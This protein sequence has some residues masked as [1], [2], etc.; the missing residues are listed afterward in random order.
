M[1][2]KYRPGYVA[3]ERA[4]SKLGLASRTQANQ[5]IKAG[6]VQVNGKVVRD[7]FF[8]VRPEVAQIKI[9][10]QNQEQ[11]FALVI[12]LN[13][14]KGL[15]TTR[16]DEKNRP[17]IYECLK[18]LKRHVIPVG[19]LDLATSG[20]LLLTND[21]RFSDWVTDPVNKVKKVY[22]ATVRGEVSQD[23]LEK[24][25]RG[26][27]DEGELLKADRAVLEKS[28]KRESHLE[29]TLTE[30]KNREIRRL[31]KALGHEVSRLKRIQIGGLSLGELELGHWRSLTQAEVNE[32]FPGT[33]FKMT[34]QQSTSYGT[35]AL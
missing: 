3:L 21:T 15:V 16:S 8:A 34:W 31:C 1:P 28:S 20:L 24:M 11:E 18:D 7:P 13:K 6:R 2:S 14:P 35:S 26:I 30:G 22:L 19:R 23:S 25:M 33:K 9:D 29:L 12:A 4:L 32:A 10:D 5:W 17:T 27:R